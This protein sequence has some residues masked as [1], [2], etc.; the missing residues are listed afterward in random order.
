VTDS[1][2]HA[3]LLHPGVKRFIEA[4]GLSGLQGSLDKPLTII[5]I[6]LL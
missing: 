2:K 3:S 5:C 1:D 6:E 4:V